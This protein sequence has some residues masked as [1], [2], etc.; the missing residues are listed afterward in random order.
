MRMS[1]L[2]KKKLADSRRKG[3]I[4]SAENYIKPVVGGVWP[5]ARSD[6]DPP[7]F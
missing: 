6:K 4:S 1:L 3:D 7:E 2:S 5:V